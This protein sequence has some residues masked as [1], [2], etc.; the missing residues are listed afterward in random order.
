MNSLKMYQAT[1]YQLQD[2]KIEAE[3]SQDLELLMVIETLIYTLEHR[4]NNGQDVK[5]VT[6]L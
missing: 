2:A 6:R 1:V 4:I 3:K 5:E